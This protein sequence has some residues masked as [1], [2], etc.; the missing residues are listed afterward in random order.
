MN[1][2]GLLRTLSDLSPTFASDGPPEAVWYDCGELVG[3]GVCGVG[4]S[5]TTPRL[6]API[7]IGTPPPC[8]SSA[9]VT[10]F[11]G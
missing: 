5:R 6:A 7:S 3:T 8:S 4:W 1:A 2:T 9:T 10:G 11:R